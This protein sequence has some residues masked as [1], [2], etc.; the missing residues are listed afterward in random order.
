MVSPIIVGKNSYGTV[1]EADT[2]HDDSPNGS[3]WSTKSADQKARALIEAVRELE[4]SP[5]GGSQ[6]GGNIVD[7]A[8]INAGGTGYVVNDILSGTTG[9]GLVL[10]VTVTS[11]SGGVVDGIQLLDAGCYTVDPTTTAE[12]TTGGTGTGCTLNLTLTA[13]VLALPRSG[14]VDRNG[15]AYSSTEYPQPAKDAEFALALAILLDTSL[16]TSTS[17]TVNEKRLKAGSV[18]LENFRPVEGSRFPSHV[19]EI[20]GVLLG[21]TGGIGAI[22]ATGT[23]AESAFDNC[24]TYGRVE[25]FA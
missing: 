6:T 5:Y 11:V 2:Y 19:Q 25:G 20:I 15:N 22:E 16:A 4:R 8:A 17:T 9:T 13:Q 1:A 7:A 21:S 14:L 23:S 3:A 24:D 10:R 12:A 18:E